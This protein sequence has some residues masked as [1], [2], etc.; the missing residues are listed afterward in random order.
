MVSKNPQIV[1][2]WHVGRCSWVW[3]DT[4]KSFGGFSRGKVGTVDKKA[5][6]IIL[7]LLRQMNWLDICVENK[8]STYWSKRVCLCWGGFSDSYILMPMH[9]WNLRILHEVS[10]SEGKVNVTPMNIAYRWLG[11]GIVCRCRIVIGCVNVEWIPHFTSH[12]HWLKDVP[13]EV[14]PVIT[15]LMKVL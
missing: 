8:G 4:G 3:P 12:N 5:I 9:V 10:Q 7:N 13:L 6:V 2:R 1:R 14:L 11:W 15:G